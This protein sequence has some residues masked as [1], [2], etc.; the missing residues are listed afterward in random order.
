LLRQISSHIYQVDWDEPS[1]GIQRALKIGD[2]PYEKITVFFL[3][4]PD[5]VPQPDAP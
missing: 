1:D 3:V 2:T 5:D 4:Q